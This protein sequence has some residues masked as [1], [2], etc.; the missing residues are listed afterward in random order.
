MHLPTPTTF[1]LPLVLNA[2]RLLAG[3][4]ALTVRLLG[5]F[6]MLRRAIA[7]HDGRMTWWQCEPITAAT[8]ERC[9]APT[10]WNIPWSDDVLREVI[11]RGQPCR[12]ASR[13]AIVH[14]GAPIVW[15][16]RLWG[17]LELRGDNRMIIGAEE[18]ALID[19]L[20][21]LLAAAIASDQGTTEALTLTARQQQLLET[22]RAELEAPLDLGGLLTFLLRWALDATGAEAGAIALVD[23]ERKELVLQA[24]EGYGRDPLS[25]DAF[26]EARRRWSW[27]VGVA[28]KVARTGRAAILRDV[29]R[30]PDYRPLNPEVRAELVV[31]IGA[32]SPLA[33]L[34]L[35][36]PRSAAFGDSE[37]AFVN[38]LCDLAVNPLRRA[39]HYQRAFET[40]AHLGQV[41]ASMPNGLVLMDQQG[42]VLRHNP[43]WLTIW[44][45]PPDSMSDP[46]YIPLDL[47]PLLLPRLRNPLALTELCEEGQR[48]PTEI[49]SLLVCLNNPHQELMLLS[50]PTRDSFGS[51][52]GRLWI[53]SDVTRER[54]A[55]RLKSEFLSIVSHELRTPLTS[56]MGYTELLLARDFTPGEQREFI[57][58]V[59]DEANHLYQIVEDLLGATRLEAG[60]VRLDRWAVS[61]RQIISDLVSHLNNQIGGKHTMLIDIPPHLPPVYAD[62]DKV[63]Q[64]LVNLITNAVKYSP[65]GGEIRL[66][67][68][69]HAE[70]PPDHPKG[71]FVR[72]AVSDQ[73]IGIAPE[74]LPRIWERFY[75]VDNGNTRRIGG[76]GLGLSIAKALVEL[77][78][79]RIWA[80]SKLNKGSTFYFTLPV[81]T[82]LVRR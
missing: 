26:G 18:Q 52:T 17:V 6:D 71:E 9:Y 7:F 10:S 72:I 11:E 78:G 5:L 58:T 30:D 33:V 68:T 76:T 14:Y 24:Y 79:G 67:V 13:N 40:S 27:E 54:E 41:F 44:G 59:Y 55:D 62:R 39:L 22:L 81:A 31:P 43:A 74:D 8:G 19:A 42:R 1:A 70:L 57:K 16:G 73:G 37:V 32:E 23:R 80:E 65:N 48:S 53:V 82:D 63:R 46:F 38:A 51:L 34:I 69:G 35:D 29:S 61:L 12:N 77:H 45:L 15:N 4:Q 36:S 50:A 3:D 20:A 21:P 2:S 64:V 25:R 60:N 56:I 75:R 47:V 49:Q 66:T 28:G